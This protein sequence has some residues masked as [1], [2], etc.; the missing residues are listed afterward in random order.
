MPAR[1]NSHALTRTIYT[2]ASFEYFSS[3]ILQNKITIIVS[4]F[5]IVADYNSA[6]IGKKKRTTTGI[7]K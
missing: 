6:E 3:Y 5:R 7:K 1:E 4:R 2:S